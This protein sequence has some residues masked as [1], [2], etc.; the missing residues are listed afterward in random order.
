M[1]SFLRRASLSLVVVL[2]A[3][4]TASAQQSILEQVQALN[5][6][7]G[8]GT[9]Q[10]GSLA[11]LEIPEGFQFAGKP[12]AGKFIEL[13]ENPSDGTELGLL[14]H[15]TEHWF[16]VFEFADDG[17]IKDDDRDL[18]ASGML[19]SIREG[20]EASNEI[21]KQ[22]GWP[23]MSVVGWH[24]APFYDPKT[25]N[26]TWAIKGASEGSEN[27]NHSTRL[28]GRRGVMKV[29]LVAS[30]DEIDAALPEF[31]TMLSTFSYTPGNKY[32][33]FTRGDKIAEYGLAGLVVGGTGVALVKSGLLQKF[34]K[35]IVVGFLALA[36]V[37]KKLLAG[38]SGKRPADQNA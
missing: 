6:Q 22:R 3:A 35:L 9:A 19:K 14:M 23:T 37:V 21:R 8:P 38:L 5:W 2:L 32:A 28:L 36:S 24:Q 18:D 15:S 30:V 31:N 16:V 4:P 29:A 34:W 33:E 11:Q 12:D 25:N 27:I 17:Y 1:R 13:M 7:V 26:L 10:I 20:T